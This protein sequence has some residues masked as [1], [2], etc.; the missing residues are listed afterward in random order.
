MTVIILLPAILVLCAPCA[1]GCALS[2]RNFEEFLPFS[3]LSIVLIQLSF[4]LFGLLRVGFWL[5]LLLGGLT[6]LAVLILLLQKK[7]LPDFRIRF[8]DTPFLLFLALCVLLLILNKGKMLASWDEFSHWGDV[9]IMMLTQDVLSI[10][11][12]AHCSFP[13]YPPALSLFEYFFSRLG[14]LFSGEIQEWLLY[15]AHQL[16]LFLLFFP[17]LKGKKL[18]EPMTWILLAGV[19]LLPTVFLPYVY[20]MIYIDVILGCLL[21]LSLYWILFR[22]DHDRLWLAQLCSMLVLLV[23]CKALGLVLALSAIIIGRRTLG[24]N[25]WIPLGSVL[26]SALVWWIAVFLYNVNASPNMSAFEMN[27]SGH[28][29]MLAD[30]QRVVLKD[31]LLALLSRGEAV[32]PALPFIIIFPLFLVG[33]W[34][35]FGRKN[36]RIWG[37]LL[38]FHIF[39]TLA[40]GISYALFFP[41]TDAQELSAM[42]RYWGNILLADGILLFLGASDKNRSGVSVFLLLILFLFTPV[43]STARF[44][45]RGEVRYSQSQRAPYTPLANRIKTV[46]PADSS[47]LLDTNDDL[48]GGMVLH[49]TLRPRTVFFVSMTGTSDAAGECPYEL[50]YEKDQ[51]EYVLY[52]YRNGSREV[53]SLPE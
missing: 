5:T 51:G 47:I 33:F 24:K 34:L 18:R 11:P 26:L 42:E 30:W 29:F 37:S 36:Y 9:V 52:H 43:R 7:T 22:A 53:I 20:A 10:D 21:G 28:A 32:I 3:L 19:F 4:G 15:Y 1:L 40:L 31:Y 13:E 39:F 8:V 35:L 2:K 50:I 44:L 25:A 45:M 27:I 46:V 16:F 38:L 6:W 12:S 23:W 49:T 17:L 14:M 41:R 48:F